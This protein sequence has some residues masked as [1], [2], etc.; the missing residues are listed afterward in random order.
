MKKHMQ[1]DI[2]NI[3]QKVKQM[4]FDEKIQYY[5]DCYKVHIITGIFLA[6]CFVSLCFSII[7]GKNRSDYLQIIVHQDCY[8]FL[9]SQ[10]EQAASTAGFEDQLVLSLYYGLDYDPNGT[11]WMQLVS[12]I[13]SDGMDLAVL[14]SQTASY[15]MEQRG[16]TDRYLI[17]P[18]DQTKLTPPKSQEHYYI[19]I[20][21]CSVRQT[22][23]DSI[24]PL[25]VE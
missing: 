16:I 15:L 9:G 11:E 10:L 17:Y 7:S 24:K 12:S 25:I 6:I 3:R 5:W 23:V 1:K 20:D 22:L 2:A 13:S 19:F 18:L 21:S 4:S 14:D 8:D